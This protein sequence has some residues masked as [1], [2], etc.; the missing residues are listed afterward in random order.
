MIL[1]R[2]VLYNFRQFRGRHE[3]EFLDRDHPDRNVVV[4]HGENG[5]GKT[6]LFRAVM[7]CLYGERRLSQ[8]ANVP[9]EEVQ[10]VN[11]SALHA[12]GDE[13]VHAFVEMT[14]SHRRKRYELRREIRGLLID[15]R[16]VEETTEVRLSI[17]G[18][19]GNTETIDRRDI[20]RMIAEVLDRR[21]REYFLFD[22]E[23]IEQLTRSGRE[24]R[25]AISQ[26]MRSLL[27]VDALETAMKASETA[28]KSF[29][30]DLE[31][32]SGDSSVALTRLLKSLGDHDSEK[33]KLNET[34][35]ERQN[36][37]DHAE[38]EFDDIEK[39][40]SEFR[41]IEHL[42]DKRR[43]REDK[44][45]TLEQ[46]A[47]SLM[48]Q[49]QNYV[50]KAAA[51]IVADAVEAAFSSLD[52]QK[53]KGEIP[54]E[55]RRDLI[56]RIMEEHRC[57]CGSEVYEGTPAHENINRWLM[58]TSDPAMEDA[59]LDLWRF[60]AETRSRF[61]DDA[62]AIE[63]QIIEH[64]NVV[65]DI[66][67]LLKEIKTLSD[68]LGQSERD[69]ARE[70]EG[71]RR[72]CLESITSIKAEI[73]NLR[74][75]LQELDSIGRRLKQQ[76]EEEKKRAHRSDTVGRRSVLAREVHDA[77]TEV[78]AEYTSEVRKMIGESA[79]RILRLLL[80]EK[81]KAVLKQIVVNEDYSLEMLDQ[82]GR[83]F[84]A[85]VSAGQR[86]VMSISYITALAMAASS[87]D[88]I[89][90]PLFMDTPFGR[91]S[92]E[93]R[94][95]I[96]REVPQLTSQWVILATDTEFR[97]EEASALSKTE[98]WARFYMLRGED[99]GNTVITEFDVDEVYSILPRE[100]ERAV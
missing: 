20:D 38:Q 23:K 59:A 44:L 26:G 22:G 71:I 53:K 82:F 61:A 39:R 24:Q 21:V 35:R 96:I 16:V 43:D 27:R 45:K 29:Q 93:H 98:K 85:N 73:Q 67:G 36:E 57:I 70:L 78:H 75:Q 19:D 56:E 9:D 41:E 17:T 89:E 63:K 99:D 64:S 18:A 81:G 51:L 11:T 34:L 54:S 84:L 69:D 86:Q 79:T 55:I 50:C 94:A 37:L 7:F 62:D 10:L 66:D 87:G 13:P 40:L 65:H 42:L 97:R 4:V 52:G 6:G 25:R 15:G 77:L 100:E 68:E 8:D 91:L 88:R 60:L 80:D 46:R 14:F 32:D 12:S 2:M 5:R 72:S 95:N 1:Q 28:V 74:S 30:S 83:A 47:D 3:I 49:M 48:G 92:G 76:L 33:E 31:R 58:R 90:M